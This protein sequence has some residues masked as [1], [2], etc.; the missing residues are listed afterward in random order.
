MFSLVFAASMSM[1]VAIEELA[2]NVM[3]ARQ[4]G[5]PASKIVELAEG[6]PVAEE[7]VR[8]SYREPRYS[9]PSVRNEAI[10]E[11]ANYWFMS[12]LNSE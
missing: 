11:F 10:R 7:M 1:C 5:V 2:E 9:T 3:S 6:I 4:A 12:C 8:D